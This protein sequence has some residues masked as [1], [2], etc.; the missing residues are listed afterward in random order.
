MKIEERLPS[1]QR[2]AG[3]GT[4]RKGEDKWGRNI[5]N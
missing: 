4:K 1:R 3:Y 2:E 5:S